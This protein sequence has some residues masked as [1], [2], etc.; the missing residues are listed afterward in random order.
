M[1]TRTAALQADVATVAVNGATAATIVALPPSSLD[2]DGTG[3]GGGYS[4]GYFGWR[5]MRV[6]AGGALVRRNYDPDIDAIFGDTYG[7]YER[8]Y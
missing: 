3:Y 2:P 6:Y 8:G 5:Q 4:V 1:S 7:S